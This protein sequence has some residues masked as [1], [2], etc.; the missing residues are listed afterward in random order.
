MPKYINNPPYNYEFINLAKASYSP[1]A[2]H[3]RNSYLYNYYVKY[4]FMKL[5]SV[6]KFTGLPEQWAENY[7]KYV[8]LG[9]GFIAILK[10]DKYGV[11]P[12]LCSIADTVTIFKQ[13]K[14]VLIANPVLDVH[15]R[16]IGDGC[17]LIKLQPDFSSPLDIVNMYAD[18]MAIAMETATVNLMNSK[19]S[20]IFF[21]PNKNIAET[22]KALY[23]DIASGKPF[24]VIDKELLNEDGTHN[25]DFFTQN[26]GQN[27][28]TDRIL[29]DMKSI[30]DQFNTKIGIPNA[31]TQKRE[32]LISS[33]V[34]ANDIDT[35]ALIHVWLD[36][37]RADIKKVNE[38]FNLN[39]NVEYA[40]QNFYNDNKEEVQDGTIEY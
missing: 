9:H 11:I 7:F 35:M 18:L 15:E 20:F 17:E 33:E 10:T 25:W 29:N 30:E 3:T 22:Y 32:R 19:A 21:A 2:I 14:R 4:L 40:Y 34:E 31:N 24:S 23:D 27:Y 1:S 5:V 16:Q 37:L 6:F 38:E 12:Q 8:L 36:S 26:V 28:I 39:I 13:P